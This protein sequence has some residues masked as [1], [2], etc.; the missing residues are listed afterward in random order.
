LQSVEVVA[1]HYIH[2]FFSIVRESR[3]QVIGH[4]QVPS[5]AAPTRKG[6][7]GHLSQHF[8]SEAVI[9]ALR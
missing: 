2:Y 6:R 3:T 5:F 1:S 4:R 7:P 8:L 9:A